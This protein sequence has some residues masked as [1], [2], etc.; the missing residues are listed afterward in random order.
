MKQSRRT[1]GKAPAA[2]SKPQP[3]KPT[4]RAQIQPTDDEVE[5]VLTRLVNLDLQQFN[6]DLEIARRVYRSNPE[7]VT[8]ERYPEPWRTLY[9]QENLGQE[10]SDQDTQKAPSIAELYEQELPEAQKLAT[11]RT[12]KLVAVNPAKV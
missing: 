1:T 7:L 10:P 11:E 5:E 2:T 12:A 9:T 6:C 3:E 4:E 8:S